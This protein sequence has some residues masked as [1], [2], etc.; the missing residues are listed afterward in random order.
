MYRC[1]YSNHW[2][3]NY[4]QVLGLL[5]LLL[6]FGSLT[7]GCASNAEKHSDISL[8]WEVEPDPPRVG[9]T[10][11]DITLTDSTNQLIKGAKVELQGNM[12]H[13]GMKPV[14]VTAEEVK[15]GHYS[16]DFDFTMGGDWFFIITST[17]S[18]KRVVEREITIP[19][20]R[21]KE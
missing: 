7:A 11:M 13:P 18:D 15:P 16:A 9:R 2:S 19:G 1:I 12:S 5:F 17:L 21:S 14:V 10:T 3:E 20:V 8:S 6:L 4:S